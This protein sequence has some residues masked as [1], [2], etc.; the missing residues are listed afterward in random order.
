M[1][2]P[3]IDDNWWDDSEPYRGKL[4][5]TEEMDPNDPHVLPTEP[6]WL[7]RLSKATGT[8]SMSAFEA[9]VIARYVRE[10]RQA[11]WPIIRQLESVGDET[12]WQGGDETDRVY[13]WYE[14]EPLK[15]AILG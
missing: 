14:I 8:H 12:N 11:A 6:A 3:S 13:P 9:H 2:L 4:H 7:T 10:V 5:M 15:K 1:G